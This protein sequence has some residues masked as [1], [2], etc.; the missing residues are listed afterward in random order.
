MSKISDGTKGRA[1]DKSQNQN[2]SARTP[3]H[4][5]GRMPRAFCGGKLVT[6]VIGLTYRKLFKGQIQS[7]RHGI[8]LLRPNQ[9]LYTQTV[10]IPDRYYFIVVSLTSH[11]LMPGFP[12]RL[13]IDLTVSTTP[14]WVTPG[15]LSEEVRF[16]LFSHWVNP[17]FFPPPGG[18]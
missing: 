4:A 17:R 7:Y 14:Y 6:F 16:L 12:R 5:Y 9:F 8:Q 1:L 15:S 3:S 2:S 11:W 10:Q 13:S 18:Y